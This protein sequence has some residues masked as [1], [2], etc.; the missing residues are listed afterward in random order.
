MDIHKNEPEIVNEYNILNKIKTD[1]T[2]CTIG[3]SFKNKKYNRYTDIIPYDEYIVDTEYYVN[4]SYINIDGTKYKNKWIASDSPNCFAIL[5]F[6]KLIWNYNVQ[7][8]VTLTKFESNKAE[9]YFNVNEFNKNEQLDD[10]NFTFIN[11]KRDRDIIITTLEL[12]INEEKKIVTHIQLVTWPDRDVISK[13]LLYTLLKIVN[14][15]DTNNKILVHCSAGI[16]RTGTFIAAY[17]S[18]Y[19]QPKKHILDIVKNMRNC[20]CL[21]VQTLNQYKLIYATKKYSHSLKQ[22]KFKTIK[23]FSTS[24]ILSYL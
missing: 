4:A 17:I 2:R 14:S 20:R 22:S 15:F 8:I 13:E 18:I 11:E 12:N 1:I 19:E 5:H 9:K 6:W 10:I 24:W 3:N 23:S 16:G 7:I 21:M